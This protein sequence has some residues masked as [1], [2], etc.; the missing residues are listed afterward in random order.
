MTKPKGDITEDSAH[1]SSNFGRPWPADGAHALKVSGN[2]VTSDPFLF[3]KQQS[4]DREKVF[5]HRVYSASSGNFGYFEVNEN[6]SD[7]CKA[8]FLNGIGKKTP[9]FLRFSAVTFEREFP[10]L[11]RNPRG[12]AVKFYTAEGNHDIVGLDWPIF[13]TEIPCRV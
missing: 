10:D 11:A 2:P 4:F 13:S 5:E 3:E 9:L 6:V 1:M 7:I 8:D 12:F